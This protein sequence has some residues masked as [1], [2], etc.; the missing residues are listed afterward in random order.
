LRAWGRRFDIKGVVN[1]ITVVDI[2]VITRLDS[3]H[4]G[5]GPR[6]QIQSPAGALST[7]SLHAYPHLWDDFRSAFNSSRDILALLDIY[8]P[9]KRHPGV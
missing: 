2:M 6:L 4:A 3:R 1:D 7:S 5:S 8:A 9:A